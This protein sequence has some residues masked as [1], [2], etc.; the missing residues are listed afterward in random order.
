MCSAMISS[1]KNY[2]PR[3]SRTNLSFLKS[4]AIYG[5]LRMLMHVISLILEVARSPVWAFGRSAWIFGKTELINSLFWWS[6]MLL[7][8]IRIRIFSPRATPGSIIA[9]GMRPDFLHMWCAVWAIL[10]IAE[11]SQSQVYVKYVCFSVAQSDSYS[12]RTCASL[13]IW[14]FNC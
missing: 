4:R 1:F 7:E 6:L 5:F 12:T 10:P 14:P 11:S 8:L 2:S 9:A 13:G 3:T